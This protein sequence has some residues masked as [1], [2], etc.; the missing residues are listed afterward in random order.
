MYTLIYYFI[1]FKRGRSYWKDLSMEVSDCI[2]THIAEE[3]CISDVI[4]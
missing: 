4:M 1:W 3:E 2:Y